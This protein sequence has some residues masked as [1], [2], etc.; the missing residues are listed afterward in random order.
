MPQRR[1]PSSPCPRCRTWSRC[2]WPQQTSCAT[3]A[4][5]RGSGPRCSLWRRRR[6]RARCRRE[7]AWNPA[8]LLLVSLPLRASVCLRLWVAV[9]AVCLHAC[10]CF[11]CV[12]ADMC[13]VLLCWRGGNVVISSPM[14]CCLRA[15]EP[16]SAAGTP[17]S[18]ATP[19]QSAP[20]SA[21]ITVVSVALVALDNHPASHQLHR[22]VLALLA[23]LA[24]SH[25]CH[26]RLLEAGVL[27]RLV[28]AMRTFEGDGGRSRSAHRHCLF[29]SSQHTSAQAT[30]RLQHTWAPV[31][32][33][34]TLPHH[35][36]LRRH[37]SC[38]VR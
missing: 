21:D 4:C 5:A 11:L 29:T 7:G 17:A 1:L 30:L 35:S 10:V 15:C 28:S 31:C 9:C 25:S 33:L 22:N 19:K 6:Q 20:P 16:T 27:V 8:A 13:N 3:C 37:W 18:P 23:N 38:I 34:P 24:A 14:L 36:V 12:C 2:K 26:A 32:P